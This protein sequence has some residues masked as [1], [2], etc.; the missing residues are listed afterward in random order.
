M[1]KQLLTAVRITVISIVIFGFVYPAL[2][3]GIG[4]VTWP[5]QAGGSYVRAHGRIVGSRIIGQLWT[6]PQDFAG[7]PSAAGK[8][9]YDPTATGASNDGPDSSA[10][11]ARVRASL[12]ALRSA[13]PNAAQGIPIDL[14]TASGSGIDPD[15][16]PAAAYYQAPRVA[17]ARH[18]PVA[19]VRRL[20]VAQT[21]QRTLGILG[22]PRVNVL[23]L[24]LALD[25]L[26]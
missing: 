4:R 12:K 18:L 1:L 10:L 22:E 19:T 2:I 7:R 17:R 3:W 14:L 23:E 11:L 25:R 15:I 6:R 9:G 8:D 5:N 20:I 26:H 21:H 24:N 13:N 16:T